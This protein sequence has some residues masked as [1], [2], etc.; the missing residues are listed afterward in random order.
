MRP[1]LT[2]LFLCDRSEHHA[3]FLSA[4]VAAEFE[5][6]LAHRTEQAKRYLSSHAVDAIVIYHPGLDDIAPVTGT[7]KRTAPSTPILRLNHRGE[8][9]QPG[10]DATFFADLQDEVL[11]RA[12]ALFLRQSLA[13][14][15]PQRVAEPARKAGFLAANPQ[16]AM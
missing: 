1:R 13:G 14:A 4:L 9:P 10:I 8:G 11:T 6:V 5:P 7:L 2:L 15:S 16:P 3:L 12:V